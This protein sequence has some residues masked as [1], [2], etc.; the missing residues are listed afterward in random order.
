MMRMAVAA[1]LIVAFAIPAEAQGT[2][3]PNAAMQTVG[4][5][6]ALAS[7]TRIAEALLPDGT[8]RT[9]MS[10]TFDKMLSGMMD[11]MTDLPMREILVASGMKE[12]D[13]PQIQPDAM[14]E[15]LAIIDPAYKQRIDLGMNAMMSGMVD[16]MSKYE[17]AVRAGLA[18]AYARRFTPPQLGE[19]ERF[20]ATP[21]GKSYAA[22]SMLIYTDP[23]VMD[24]MMAMVPEMMQQMP[25]MI[26]AMTEATKGLPKQ[27]TYKDLSKAERLRVAQAL[28]IDPKKM[29]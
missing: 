6:A 23:A 27:R 29:K 11:Q 19:L 2:G 24:R 1:T 10:G 15:V 5:S 8:Y 17:P 22:Q 4:E 7:A 3:E 28:G 18:E 16:M 13:V 9:M 14:K 21:T 20:F 25:K 12:E 26:G